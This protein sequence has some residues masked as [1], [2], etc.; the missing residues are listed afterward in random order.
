MHNHIKNFNH[1]TL[2]TQECKLLNYKGENSCINILE[3]AQYFYSGLSP[4]SKSTV[5][6]SANGS[7]A[8]KNVNEAWDLY[9]L[10]A[11][12]KTMFSSDRTTPRKVAVIHEIDDYQPPMQNL[13]H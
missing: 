1:R 3:Q 9:E 8:N 10:I 13:L 11:N 2:K 5:N 6:S 4:Q 7:I 12:T